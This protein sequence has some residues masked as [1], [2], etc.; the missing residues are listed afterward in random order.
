MAKLISGLS[1]QKLA[2]TEASLLVNHSKYISNSQDFLHDIE[3][4]IA[5]KNVSNLFALAGGI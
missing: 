5:H 1:N 3:N 2:Q 4:Y